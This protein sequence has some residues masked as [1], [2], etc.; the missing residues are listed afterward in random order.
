MLG[1][2]LWSGL[3]AA[4]LDE[5]LEN[6][7]NGDYKTAAKELQKL[8]K[9][10]NDKAQFFLGV[11]Y[12]SGLGVPQ[13]KN[14]AEEWLAEAAK[15]GNDAA[16]FHLNVMYEEDI[17]NKAMQQISMAAQQGD[18]NSQYTLGGMYEEGQGVPQDCK[19]A[20]KWYRKA[21]EQGNVSAQINLGVLYGQG[22]GIPQD[23]VQAYLW[24][25]LA[26]VSGNQMA[27]KNRDLLASVMTLAQLE[28]A[29]RLGRAWL[30]SHHKPKQ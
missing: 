16:R 14:K 10:G 17:N 26:A 4:G 23:N 15:Q 24:F 20:E 21:A 2:L 1:A 5:A 18:A 8:A 13:D 11:M 7:S 12:E 19:A 9:N 29:Q 6:Y 25:N 28:E 22:V 27:I 3:A 30:A